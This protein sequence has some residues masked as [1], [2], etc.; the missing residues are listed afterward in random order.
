MALVAIA[1]FHSLMLARRRARGHNGAAHRAAFQNHVRFHGRIA[2]RVQYFTRTYR[3]NLCHIAPQ[4]VVLQPVIELGT[5][6][7]GKR[8]SGGA[9]NRVQKP[10]HVHKK[11]SPSSGKSAS[12]C[13]V[14]PYGF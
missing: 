2:A 14:Y 3:N 4:N 10:V 7:H 11:S 1:Q 13:V 8:L 5:A 6:I 9:L 12:G